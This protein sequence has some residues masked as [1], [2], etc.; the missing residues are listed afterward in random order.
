MTTQESSTEPTK[1]NQRNIK[2]RLSSN[3]AELLD[4]MLDLYGHD[5]V[6]QLCKFFVE[7]GIE[8]AMTKQSIQNQADVLWRLLEVANGEVLLE[9]KDGRQ[10]LVPAK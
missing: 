4:G 9:E 5:T 1:Q 2:F 3:Q 8:L 6:H 7:K 10:L